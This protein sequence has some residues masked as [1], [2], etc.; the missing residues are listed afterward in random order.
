MNEPRSHPQNPQPSAQLGQQLQWD[1]L[2]QNLSSYSQTV[3]GKNR[4]LEL[5][6]TLG[7]D[8]IMARW[9]EVLPLKDVNNL[10]Y[11]PP[12]GDVPDMR[13][14]IR[15]AQVGKVFEG[16]ELRDVY[17]LLDVTSQVLR[18]CSDFAQQCRTLETFRARVYPLPKL[19]TAIDRA[20]DDMGEIK[21]NASA[22]LQSL[23]KEKI[24]MRKKIESTLKQLIAKTEVETYLQ[25]SFFTI[26]S[27]RYVIPIR[28]DGRGRIK[29]SIYD[30]SDSGQTLFMEPAV[31]APLNEQLLELELS[32]KLEILRIFRELSGHI[33]GEIE[34][35][36]T[37]YDEVIQLDF[38]NAQSAYA[39]AIG[40]G[41]VVIA[42]TPGLYLK[43]ARHPLVQSPEGG[44]AVAN[45]IWL[46]DEQQ[47]LVVSGPNAGGK[48]VV[49]KTTGL[50]H[51]MLKAGLLLPC[52]EESALY[53]FRSL[54]LS[55]G[56]SQ[57]LSQ[58]L[59]T[60]SGH[61]HNLKPIIDQADKESLIL[62]DEIAVGTE[63]QTGSALAQSIL[64]FLVN[65]GAT[66]IATTHF[67]PLKGLA[68]ADGRFRN[69]SMEF[70]RSDLK[71]TYRLVLDL[72]G[73]SYGL[74][75]AAKLGLPEQII[76]R[77]KTLKGETNSSVDQLVDSLLQSQQ[78][79][80]KEQED[81]YA[82][83]LEMEAQK[84]YWEREKKELN[85]L[86][87]SSSA[88][89]K[90]KYEAS[91][92]ELKDQMYEQIDAFKK[93][94]KDLRAAT[95][96]GEVAAIKQQYQ[97]LK[98]GAEQSAAELGSTLSDT[99]SEFN[100]GGRELGESLPL[101]ALTVGDEVFV[102]SI[103]KVARITKLM[104]SDKKNVALEAGLLK[105]KV[106]T[107]DLFKAPPKPSKAAKGGRTAGKGK[108][109]SGSRTD[110]ASHQGG[111]KARYVIPTP[112]NSVNLRGLTGD[113]AID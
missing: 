108:A 112:T 71:P 100:S 28:L 65:R 21:D 2:K 91:I 17:S 102:K 20:I 78:A 45:D 63:P 111:G 80:K 37:N 53:P 68:M 88:K 64:E 27:D 31:V 25:D 23:R 38:I 40:A 51:L 81:Y 82:L 107:S 96:P 4:C 22:K 77:A 103:G 97:D 46:T 5:S 19:A 76:S 57:D 58:Q 74:E 29:G 60:F 14:I 43:D 84:S 44:K 33:A 13:A 109:R 42:D 72:P 16:T 1:Q 99:D 7:P 35:I 113:E 39:V 70:S 83:K 92:D 85:Q 104:P 41:S 105:L 95:T 36:A 30:T 26:R 50:L 90:A 3:E 89:V 66:L 94:F 52:H 101:D 32:E 49:L 8:E 79:A 62:L 10:G 24:A 56:D 87:R 106:N 54:H 110:A 15:G 55:L 67:D 59:S 98:K 75:V 9:N 61:I 47:A 12:I 93:M 73:Q 86:K 48:T 34:I 18:F 11:S 6:P 69:G